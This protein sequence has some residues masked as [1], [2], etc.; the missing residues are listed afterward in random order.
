MT[1]IRRPA[2]DED[3]LWTFEPIRWLGSICTEHYKGITWERNNSR[4]VTFL[5]SGHAPYKDGIGGDIHLTCR[6]N[7][8]IAGKDEI[9][10]SMLFVPFQHYNTSR[11]TA[12]TPGWNVRAIKSLLHIGFSIEGVMDDYYED[13][14]GIIMGLTRKK[15]LE[16]MKQRYKNYSDKHFKRRGEHGA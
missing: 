4:I 14:D 10:Y 2:K 6:S 15:G 16:I 11:L 12:I 8:R 1:L 9:I 13:A 5:Y 3:I 7:S